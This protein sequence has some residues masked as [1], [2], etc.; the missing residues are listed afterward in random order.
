[1][2]TTTRL[3]HH[4]R[5]LP[6]PGV[7]LMLRLSDGEELVGVRPRY[8]ESRDDHDLGYETL[9]GDRVRNVVEW[10]IL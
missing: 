2:Q 7:K 5:A 9:T 1:M 10:S 8:I 4:C 6:T 3:W